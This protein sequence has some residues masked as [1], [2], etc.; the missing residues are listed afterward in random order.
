MRSFVV[1]ILGFTIALAGCGGG[2]STGPAIDVT[3]TYRVNGVSSAGSRFTATVVVQQGGRDVTG[4]YTNGRS[5]YRIDGS[6]SGTH[7]TGQLIGLN[8]PAVCDVE[9][10]LRPDAA[11][12]RLAGRPACDVGWLRDELGLARRG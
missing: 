12:D 3:G 1:L 10:D 9:A 5:Q 6:V 4:T 11:R 7:F 8:N 2:G